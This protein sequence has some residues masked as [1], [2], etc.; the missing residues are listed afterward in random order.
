MFYAHK[1]DAF[2][3]RTIKPL[4]AK[5]QA[6]AQDW[7]L[8][9]IDLAAKTLKPGYIMVAGSEAGKPVATVSDGTKKPLGFNATWGTDI[10]NEIT[11]GEGTKTSIWV[12]GTDALF[13]LDKEVIDTTAFTP[14]SG[15]QFGEVVYIGADANGKATIVSSKSL[16]VAK[17]IEVKSNGIVIAGLAAND[18]TGTSSVAVLHS[19]AV[20]VGGEKKYFDIDQDTK[21]GTL[22]LP[23]GTTLTGLKG[24]FAVSNGA[25]LKVGNTAQVSGTTTN[26]WTDGTAITFTTTAED[27]TTSVNYDLTITIS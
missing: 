27:T 9:K 4:Y 12:L 10:M 25:T 6:T 2:K 18:D 15:P 3:E 13:F 24:Y 16:A 26:T 1:D 22:E 8:S 14:S 11:D 20:E 19:Y 5:T 23:T 17:L 7:T 21:K